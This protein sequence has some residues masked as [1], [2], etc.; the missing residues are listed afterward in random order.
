MV[1]LA[2]VAGAG[3]LGLPICGPVVKPAGCFSTFGDGRPG[4]VSS[5]DM[6]DEA[7]CG[8]MDDAAL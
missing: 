8:D 1:G 6:G 5:G 3:D 4:F 7:A 2:R